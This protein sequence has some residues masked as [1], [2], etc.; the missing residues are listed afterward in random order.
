MCVCGGGGEEEA[1]RIPC[2][3]MSNNVLISQVER[4]R[5][6]ITIQVYMQYYWGSM[7]SLG[8]LLIVLLL[9]QF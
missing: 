2:Y 5:A 1:Q 7:P 8:P 3:V 4:E 9:Q 6:A